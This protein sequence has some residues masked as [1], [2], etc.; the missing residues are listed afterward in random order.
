MKES[1]RNTH[2][3]SMYQICIIEQCLSHCK[4]FI[5]LIDFLTNISEHFFVPRDK[6]NRYFANITFKSMTQQGRSKRLEIYSTVESSI[7]AYGF[8]SPLN[9]SNVCISI[10]KKVLLKLPR[11]T[12]IKRNR[13]RPRCESPRYLEPVSRLWCQKDLSRISPCF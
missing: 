8:S 9:V 7:I 4:W 13:Q 10:W 5:E 3:T 2:D 11:L 12:S 6:S 1:Y